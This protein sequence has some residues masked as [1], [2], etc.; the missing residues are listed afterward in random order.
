MTMISQYYAKV[1]VSTDLAQL[2]KI[3][4]YLMLIER[5][6][7]AFQKKAMTGVGGALKLRFVVDEK[8]LR[9]TVGDSFDRISRS[10][11][12]EVSRFTVN[13]R[14]LQAALLRAG[15]RVSTGT[16][17]QAPSINRPAQQTRGARDYRQANFLHAGGAAGALS[18]YG[19]GSLPF[20]GGVYGMGAVN[21]MS[22]EMQANQLAL[23][24]AA[25]SEAGGTQYATF[26]DK[27]GTRL[28][29]TTRTMSPFFSQML[30]GAKGTAL[31]P[32]LQTGFSSLME[33][34]S[35]MGLDDQKIKGTIR[36]FT[37]MIGKQQ[38]MAEELRGQ[39]AEHLPPVVRLMADVAAGGDVKKLNKMMEMGQLDPNVHLPLLFERLKQ[40]SA[41]LLP[42]YFKTSRFAQGSME[43]A[44]EDS[45]K[46]FATSG[47][48]QGF[49][50]FFSRV[51]DLLKSADP[52]FRGLGGAFNELTQVMKA[53]VDLFKSFAD[54]LVLVQKES[55]LS[56]SALTS[57]AAVGA[58]MTTKWGRIAAMFTGILLVLQDIS[59]GMQGKDSYTKDFMELTNMTGPLEKGLFGVSA[60]LLAVAAALKTV[61]GASSLPGISDIFGKRGGKVDVP[62]TL[63][64]DPRTWKDVSNLGPKGAGLITTLGIAGLTMGGLYGLGE[65]SGIN[66]RF[67]ANALSAQERA[68]AIYGD[69]NSIYYKDPVG[70]DTQMR[71]KALA[72]MQAAG[73]QNTMNIGSINVEVNSSEWVGETPAE[74]AQQLAD[75]I[76]YQ[77]K[78][79]LLGEAWQMYPQT[80]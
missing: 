2:R 29:K 9:K 62:D 68:Q 31:E 25:G 30:A 80:Q 24:A 40:E 43:K 47:G 39:A 57:L 37:Q 67:A 10:V 65:V 4:R 50:N 74:S 77:V 45:L 22:Q 44:A 17:L 26:L 52:I 36:A 16:S 75:K 38:I 13:D 56:E 49:F 6:F 34:S 8:H 71:E 72:E 1:G 42:K 54:V 63:K 11:V 70:Y 20:I 33:Y 55:G 53:P 12:F 66:D 79:Q 46:A 35:V 3:D 21:R 41:P 51:K 64:R 60:A 18:R 23:Q 76:I 58:L 7:Q 48:D 32:H 73:N 78:E 5:K 28:G 27:L 69:P 14:N 15:R 19:V 59:Y 61:S